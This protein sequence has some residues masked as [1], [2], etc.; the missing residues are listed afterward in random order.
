MNAFEFF[1]RE[2]IEGGPEIANL[3]ERRGSRV[4]D[5]GAWSARHGED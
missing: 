4:G 2:N 5:F 1:G 3:F